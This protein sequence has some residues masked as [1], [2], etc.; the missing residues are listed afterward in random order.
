MC[1]FVV[2]LQIK[3]NIFEGK[4][5][6]ALPSDEDLSKVSW[7]G[8]DHQARKLLIQKSDILIATN[9]NTIEWA[10]G[11]KHSKPEE[12][13]VE[14][15]SLKPCIGGSDAHN[16][17]ELYTKNED[18]Q[19]W[20]KADLTFEGLKQITH[21]P[22][23]RVKIQALKPD[24]KNERYIISELEYIDSSN[25]FGNQKILLNENLNAII[26]GK[27]SGKSLLIFST[28]KSI[29]PEQVDKASKRLGFEGYKFDSAFDFNAVWK[30]GDVDLYS[31]SDPRSKL[32]KITY[33]PQLYI[34]YLVE[35]NNKEELNILIKNILLQDSTFK[36]FYEETTKSISDTTSEIE[37]LIN[38]YFKVRK[39]A[40]D[41]QQKSKDTGNSENIKKS[42][43]KIEAEILQGQKASNLSEAEFADYNKL[44]TEKSENDSFLRTINLK[45][46]TLGKVVTEVNNSMANLLGKTEDSQVY[47]K[48]QVDRILDELGEV[49]EELKAIKL[50]IQT[51]FKSLIT[52]LGIEIKNLDLANSKIALNEKIKKN[53]E[54]LAP[55]LKKI[56][57]QK[58]LQKLATQLESEKLKY[59]NA[60]ALE[61]QFRNLLE[62]YG[63]IRKQ[64]ATLLK[65]RFELYRQIE[66]KVNETKKDIG[67]DIELKCS[68]IYSLNNF[69]FYEQVN[70]AAIS[71][72]HY[73]NSFYNENLI[74]YN[75][76]P[77]FYEKPLRTFEDKLFYSKEESIPLKVRTS[78]EDIL[79]GLIKDSFELDY[80]VTYKGD[81]LLQY[82][83][84]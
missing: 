38:E 34:N 74:N 13:V 11:K 68:L 47:L 4:Y 44:L 42:F 75:L 59:Q 20:I 57:G 33:I 46:I 72:D 28:A 23:E 14:F 49:P 6:I 29:D 76:I 82:V 12:F 16:F 58:E 1:K 64:T 10:L 56:A 53:G 81:N 21:E 31:N 30:N 51:D 37:R 32:H 17:D 84:W 41:V 52:N 25:L 18:R 24:V 27:S 36:L 71:N 26:G 2:C 15:K 35:K 61:K 48:G 77:E 62:E 54:K 69:T 8:Q 55:Y 9:P 67:S 43:L 5:L 50:K 22:E 19:V 45:E 63:I 65:K 40:F 80:T 70:K 73:I 83:A 66:Q 79:R 3:K 7:N 78:L 39:N 60:I